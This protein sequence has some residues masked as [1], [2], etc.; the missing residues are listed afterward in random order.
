MKKYTIYYLIVTACLGFLGCLFNVEAA[1]TLSLPS[2]NVGLTNASKPTEVVTIIKILIILTVL[3]LAPAIIIM[4]TSFT[5]IVVVLSF[6]RQALG[7]HN[8]PPNQLIIGLSLFL[9]FFVM[10]PVLT[11]IH[12]KA[13]KP[14]LDN[15]ISQEQAMKEG[16][17]RH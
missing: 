15:T 10:S 3:S 14:Y 11:N 1:D 4:M 12:S 17:K 6:L 5:R 8:M 9:T 16:Y 7:A 13:L 2:I